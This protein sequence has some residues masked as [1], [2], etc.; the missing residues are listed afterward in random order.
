VNTLARVSVDGWFQDILNTGFS[1][2]AEAA[3]CDDWFQKMKV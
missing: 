3:K 1:A 2:E